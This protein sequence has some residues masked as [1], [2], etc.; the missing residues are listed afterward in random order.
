MTL[1]RFRRLGSAEQRRIL[2]AA[3]QH[4]AA[5]GLADISLGDLADEASISRSAL[6]T[7]FD[8]RDDV[9]QAAT[10]HAVAVVEAALRTWEPVADADALWDQLRAAIGRMRSLLAARTELRPLL[11]GVDGA[12]DA[13]IGA[14]FA[15]ADRLGIV[16]ASN[17]R[18]AR[19]ATAAVLAAADALDVAQPGS[20]TPEELEEMLRHVW[21]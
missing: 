11:A 15:D 8:G 1:P 19:A 3:V 9:V 18:L 7:Y 4:I 6:Y 13:W 21:S 14:V 16:T 5:R 20:V 10:D 12:I 17:R 2:D